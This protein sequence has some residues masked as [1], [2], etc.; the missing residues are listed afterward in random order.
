MSKTVRWKLIL[1]LAPMLVIA[2][3]LFLYGMALHGR[4]VDDL[5]DSRSV[6][7]SDGVEYRV[8]H[9]AFDGLTWDNVDGTFNLV[10]VGLFA[11]RFPFF[12]YVRFWKSAQGAILKQRVLC[13][14]FPYAVDTM[15]GTF[16][17]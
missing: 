13:S 11:V 14:Y 9:V 12:E 8:E 1:L 2:L 10:D 17:P 7:K 16:Q 3:L 6:M 15:P 5:T 4:F